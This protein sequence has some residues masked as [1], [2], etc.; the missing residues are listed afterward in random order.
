M[1][2][3]K[4]DKNISGKQIKKIREAKN[5]TQAELSAQLQIKGH[6]IDDSGVSKIEHGTRRVL[7]S[8]LKSIAEILGVSANKLLDAAG[9]QRKN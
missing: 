2:H 4:T 1:K 3:I 8:E 9:E 6:K 5:I 7:D